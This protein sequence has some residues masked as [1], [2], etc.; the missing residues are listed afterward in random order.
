[1]LPAAAH[2]G[3]LIEEV[4]PAHDP[5]L[6]PLLERVFETDQPIEQI[7]VSGETR[8]EPGVHRHW[9]VS[10]YPVRP[11]S[12]PTQWV[13][14][15]FVEVTERK[16]A[17]A[18][19]AQ[20][21][22]ALEGR[23]QAQ[24]AELAAAEEEGRRS[25]ERF[26]SLFVASPDAIFVE[27]EDGVVLDANPAACRL[28]RTDRAS[29]IGR[30]VADLV[31]EAYRSRSQDDFVGLM[32]GALE[33]LESYSLTADGEPVPVEVR[34]SRVRYGG[35]PAVLLHVRDVTERRRQQALIER[36]ERLLAGVLTASL[37]GIAAL[38][39][40][41]D[42]SGAVVDFRWL[43]VNPSAAALYGLPA[44]ALIDARLSEWRPAAFG[45]RLFER[46]VEVVE[47]GAPFRDELQTGTGGPPTW[48]S[49]TVVR[50]DDGITLTT[51]D[52]TEQKAA[53]RAL[54][55]SEERFAKAFHAAPVAISI[56]TEA[57]GQFLA[58]NEHF[59]RLTGY[60]HAEVVGHT[61]AELRLYPDPGGRARLL[62][63][64]RRQ[65][66]LYDVEHPIRTRSGELRDTLYSFEL[67]EI[68]GR[69]CILAIGHDVT[70]RKRLEREVIEA[71]EIE[72]RRI[73][74]DLHDGLGQQLTGAA[75]LARGLQQRL[76]RAGAAEAADAAYLA[77]LLAETL[78][79]ARGLSRILSPVDIESDGLADALHGLAEQT[80]RTFDVP[81]QL[82]TVGDVRLDDNAAASHLFRIA[83]EA[84]NNALKHAAPSTVSVVLERK[85]G[86]LVLRVHDDGRGLPPAPTDGG[87]GLRTM[88][89]RADLIGADLAIRPD[90]AG[91]TVVACRVPLDGDGA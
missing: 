28:H 83:Q 73:G 41:R 38:E 55:E 35:R 89:Y 21:N 8:R 29:L 82:T 76:E 33:T 68:A 50:L 56:S 47:T 67:I 2:V 22:A 77:D 72:R 81:C 12:G 18:T 74:Q 54:R 7:E 87:I 36:S 64:I 32:T 85:P 65:G 3:R 10:L 14:A 63:R 37:D 17:E 60:E 78:G 52:V 20:A 75:F 53:E 44:D 4:V 86:A 46:F 88:R 27:S 71:T 91:G 25:E 11:P 39:A 43:T 42:A 23:V 15:T 48:L 66:R 70:D 5:P 61:T 16:R 30:R 45:P 62:E 31:P 24:T 49:I 13:G 90:R 69:P 26:R 51:R 6:R 58:V 40:V 9:L 34:A 59:L 84:I 79:E 57:E 80:S 19:L 1:G